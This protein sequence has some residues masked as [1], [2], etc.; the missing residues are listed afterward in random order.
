MTL[1]L[2]V[3]GGSEFKP[4]S[5][6]I[7]EF[8]IS[9]ITSSKPKIGII[10]T[11][12][13]FENPEKAARNGVKY[14]SDLGCDPKAIYILSILDSNNKIL[15]DQLFDCDIIFLTGGDPIHLNKCTTNTILETTLKKIADLGKIIIG[16]SA[17]AMVLGSEIHSSHHPG[18]SFLEKTIILPHHENKSSDQV[19]YQFKNQLSNGSTILGID[20]ATAVY[21]QNHKRSILGN[22]TVTIYS[23][24]DLTICKP[25]D[26]FIHQD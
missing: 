15:C 2:I 20:S 11:A 5:R 14:F 12:A 23:K 3:S 4:E 9:K 1:N 17:G 18:L 26:V 22:G 21:I 8:A 6:K 10:P 24:S 13:Y 16:S 19:V 7:D 25:G